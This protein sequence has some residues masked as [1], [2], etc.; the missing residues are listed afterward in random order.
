[1]LTVMCFHSGDE[2]LALANAEW[3]RDLGGLEKHQCLLVHDGTVTPA[4]AD[5]IEKTLAEAFRNVARMPLLRERAPGKGWQAENWL[6]QRVLKQVQHVNA[7]AF[8]WNHPDS[9]PLRKGWL[10]ALEAAYALL[11]R[12][13][14]F[15]GV[16]RDGSP[17]HMG[18]IGIWPQNCDHIAPLIMFSDR[19]P[20]YVNAAPKV[21]PAMAETT[22]I[23]D[24]PLTV[25]EK[26][27]HAREDQDAP[28][29][30]PATVLWHGSPDCKD[31]S[32]IDQLRQLPQDRVAP[33]TI[34]PITPAQNGQPPREHFEVP[35]VAKPVDQAA[36]SAAAHAGKGKVDDFNPEQ[37]QQWVNP[38]VKPP[39]VNPVIEAMTEGGTFPKN[40]GETRLP[41]V[42]ATGKPITQE[43]IDGDQE[44]NLTTAVAVHR[45]AENLGEAA[46]VKGGDEPF[47]QKLTKEV[48]NMITRDNVEQFA[49]ALAGFRDKSPADKAATLAALRENGF[50]ISG[51]ARRRRKS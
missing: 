34:K 37:E 50:R 31:G 24:G 38:G 30:P 35:R 14:S 8:L 23:H 7:G 51:R 11:P 45:A 47:D 18:P 28:L 4:L 25:F 3:M 19:T 1:M 40:V 20:F 39:V 44:A 5:R 15:L 36:K 21:V 32:L 2:S 6:M 33:L 42:K 22:L 17:P 48:L 26:G 10:D 49:E 9:I 43:E 16:Y 41:I 13:K 27:W 29:L 12:G 46:T